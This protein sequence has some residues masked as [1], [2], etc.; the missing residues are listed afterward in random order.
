MKRFVVKQRGFGRKYLVF[1]IKYL[2]IL[3][4]MGKKPAQFEKVIIFL[5]ETLSGKRYAIRGTASLVLQGL[6]MNVDDVDVLCDGE[7]ALFCN[8]VLKDY[9]IEDV[10]FQESP[11]FKSYFG[12][13]KIRGVQVEIMG[14]WQIKDTKG[15]WSESFAARDS[16]RKEIIL[17]AQRIYVTTIEMELQMFAKMGRWTALQKIRREAQVKRLI[18]SPSFQQEGEQNTLFD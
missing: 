3:L 5:A 13:F 18:L 10:V 14:N 2:V 17:E 15:N 7:T 12:K 1:S 4:T 11:K 6:D 8:D 16:E 9:L